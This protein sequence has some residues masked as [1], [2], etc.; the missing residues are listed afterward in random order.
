MSSEVKLMMQN[1]L[2][3]H[4]NTSNYKLNLGENLNNGRWEIFLPENDKFLIN[5][6]NANID[7]TD[8]NQTVYKESYTDLNFQK[9]K[10]FYCISFR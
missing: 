8:D 5:S 4:K 3:I 7:A 6:L 1:N 10:F 2:K 9:V